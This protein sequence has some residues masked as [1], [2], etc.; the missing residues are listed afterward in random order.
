MERKDIQNQ[1]PEFIMLS[2]YCNISWLWHVSFPGRLWG[3]I[4]KFCLHNH[5]PLLAF[6]HHLG[7]CC[8]CQTCYLTVLHVISQQITRWQCRL[9]M[10][11]SLAVVRQIDFKTCYFRKF[12]EGILKCLLMFFVITLSHISSALSEAHIGQCA[13]LSLLYYPIWFLSKH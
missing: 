7:I 5:E 11:Q 2:S 10:I 13:P 3:Q 12:L 9:T 8:F 1:G 4:K 6:Y